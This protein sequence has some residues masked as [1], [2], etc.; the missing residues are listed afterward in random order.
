MH[1]Y[2]EDAGQQR[3]PVADDELRRMLASGRLGWDARVWRDGMSG[4]SPAGDVPEL[5][6]GKPR[7]DAPV[8]RSN[9]ALARWL[10][11]LL[12]VA[13]AVDLVGALTGLRQIHIL[14]SV[15][16]G[17]EYSDAEID[18]HDSLYAGIGIAQLFVLVGVGTVFLVWFRRSYQ[19]L[20]TLGAEHLESTPG[21]A[22][23]GWFVPFLNLVR[24]YRI[25]KE[26]W[27]VSHR[28]ASY[29]DLLDAPP[30]SFTPVS[31]WWGLFI[32][33]SMLGNLGGRL[34]RRADGISA[35]KTASAVV[36]ASDLL[37]VAAALA[38]IWMIR[39]LWQV[40]RTAAERRGLVPPG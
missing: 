11:V 12:L 29:D 1:W 8:W 25:A 4:W 10:V 20:S 6:A 13:A 22:V 36:A 21:W 14:D 16:S 3:G 38:A 15:A 19:N 37:S 9:A 39:G 31:V 23:G 40:Q 33:M 5:A 2:Y 17:V 26:M 28:A 32:I 18:A 27:I 35:L 24:P 30:V 34:M 7:Q